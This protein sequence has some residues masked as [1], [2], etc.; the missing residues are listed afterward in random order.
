MLKIFSVIT[1]FF[2]LPIVL[3]SQT[4]EI[5]FAIE[6]SPVYAS[7]FLYIF[8]KNNPKGFDADVQEVRDYLDLYVNFKLKVQR[9]REL[10]LDTLPNLRE[11][12]EG[13]RRQLS[14]SYLMNKEVVENLVKELFERRQKDIN[15][16]HLLV[17]L[18]ADSDEETIQEAYER[19][20]ELREKL[21]GADS[22]SE[23]A[24]VYSDDPSAGR[25]GGNIGYITAPLPEGFYNL[26]T[27]AYETPVGEYSM[28]VRSNL[29]WHVVRV[30]DRRKARGEVEVAHILVRSTPEQNTGRT[31]EERVEAIMKK[32]DSGVPFETVAKE[33]SED[34]ATANRGGYIGFVGINLFERPFEDAAFSIEEDGAYSQPAATRIGYHIIKRISTR[35]IDDFNRMKP[36]I[37][38]Q[39]EN[40]DRK[41][42]AMQQLIQRIKEEAGYVRNDSLLEEFIGTLDE[43]FFSYRWRV[44]EELQD[45]ILF[46]LGEKDYE[47]SRFAESMRRNTRMRL[48]MSR[49]TDLKKAVTELYKAFTGDAAISHQEALLEEKYEDFRALMREY[50]EGILLFELTKMKVWDKAAADTTGL[51]NFFNE[52]RDRY[53]TEQTASVVN[54]YIKNADERRLSRIHSAAAGRSAEDVVRRFDGRR[55]ININLSRETYIQRN[56]PEGLEFSEGSMTNISNLNGD[57][58]T[59]S[60]VETLIPPRRRELHEARGFVIADFQD[61]LEKAWMEELRNRYEVQINR[62]VFERKLNLWR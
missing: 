51:R 37:E 2:L 52:N 20:L 16:S 23:V 31:A 22:F 30:N 25:N 49:D 44:P 4:D 26:E 29:G 35:P 57:V 36:L 27:A 59:F 28:P 33:H 54:F 40:S 42:L 9:A 58:H 6:D 62:D 55:D 8:N 10:Q 39:L 1:Y 15:L 7:E 21:K 11:E 19:A 18:D 41:D 43:D 56:L 48:R 47:L 53:L 12:L 32:L 61:E 3:S 60:K 24:R 38:Q 45:G 34:A 5:L 13:Y 50:E 46:T 14:R 17:G